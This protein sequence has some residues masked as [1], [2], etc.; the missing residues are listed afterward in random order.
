MKKLLMTGCFLMAAANVWAFDPTGSYT[1]REKGMTG[2]MTVTEEPTLKG[3]T[4]IRVKLDTMNSQTNMCEL[5]VAGERVISSETSIEASF[6]VPKEDYQE[7]Q[8]KFTVKFTPK[9]AI[10]ASA[11]GITNVCGMNAYFDG[12]WTKD[13]VKRKKSKK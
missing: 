7:E 5:D 10:I 4:A 1:F 3:W 11:S 13:S 6:Q 9:G 8:T 12:K 2:S